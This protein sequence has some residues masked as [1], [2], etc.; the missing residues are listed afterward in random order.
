MRVQIEF[1]ADVDRDRHSRLR[2]TQ[3]HRLRF[4]QLGP[5]TFVGLSLAGAPVRKL[6]EVKRK[7]AS[8]SSS[9]ITNHG[10]KKRAVLIG[11]SGVTLALIPDGT[12]NREW[13]E[14][15]KH[16]VVKHTRIVLISHSDSFGTT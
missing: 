14:R 13:N 5:I 11:T 7:G 3:R 9:P 16:R 12:A 8:P 1:I 10:R 4:T 15:R 6:H 2:L